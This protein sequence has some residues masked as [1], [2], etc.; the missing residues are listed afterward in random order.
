MAEVIYCAYRTAATGHLGGYLCRAQ[1]RIEVEI[2][3]AL[4]VGH[5]R[6]RIDAHGPA[7][8]LSRL[9]QL[10]ILIDT[11]EDFGDILALAQRC[12]L[13]TYDAAY[14][15]LAQ[16]KR[17]DLCTL[18]RALLRAAHDLGITTGSLQGH[19]RAQERD[20]KRRRS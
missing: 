3:N 15:S 13:T 4:L 19:L 12:E 9:R 17:A 2:T 1:S 11:G 20:A 5:R 10:P 7:A 6:G 8:A 16:R 14:L 18:D